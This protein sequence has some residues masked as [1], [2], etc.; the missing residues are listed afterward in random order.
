MKLAYLGTNRLF[1]LFKCD[2]GQLGLILPGF[3]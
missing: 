1:E 3:F 2:L